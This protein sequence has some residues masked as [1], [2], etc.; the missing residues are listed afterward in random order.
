MKKIFVFAFVL[1]L[2]VILIGCNKPNENAVETLSRTINSLK[3]SIQSSAT[4]NQE[5]LK[6]NN[7]SYNTTNADYSKNNYQAYRQDYNNAQNNTI[8]S[9]ANQRYIVRRNATT[10]N[11]VQDN[12]MPSYRTSTATYNPRYISNTNDQRATTYLENISNLYTICDDTCY[13]NELLEKTKKDIINNCDETSNALDCIKDKSLSN[14]TMSILREYCN[15]IGKCIDNI[16]TSCLNT[17]VSDTKAIS[18]L[19]NNL[20]TN[21]DKLSAKYLKVLNNID[22]N[23][24]I[25]NQTNSTINYI[26][27]Y[28]NSICSQKVDTTNTTK[29]TNQLNNTTVNNTNSTN[30]E[31]TNESNIID[32]TN[33]INGEKITY[34]YPLEK[35]FVPGTFDK[36]PADRRIRKMPTENTKTQNQPVKNEKLENNSD[37]LNNQ[38]KNTIDIDNKTDIKTNTTNNQN[39]KI[40]TNINKATPRPN[41]NN[42]SQ[43]IMTNQKKNNYN[44]IISSKNVSQSKNVRAISNNV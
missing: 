35:R 43:N 29:T 5:Q 8:N 3:N 16:N 12:N 24:A 19:K 27:D 36:K 40:I 7:T 28:V 10:Q 20:T 13:A 15:V 26:K 39:K 30:T 1:M 2:S 17:T 23:L 22:N 41:T 14:E 33:T 34:P 37:L 42:Q 25:M 18:E 32:K 44:D 31:K 9:I 38:S 11:Y 4:F 6:L 21:S